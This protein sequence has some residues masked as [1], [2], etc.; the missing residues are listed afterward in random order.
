LTRRTDVLRSKVD[1]LISEQL[2]VDSPETWRNARGDRTKLLGEGRRTYAF[3]L[4]NSCEDPYFGGTIE[5]ADQEEGELPSEDR[6]CPSCAPQIQN[7]CRHP[8]EHRGYHVWKCRYCCRPSNHVCYGTVHFCQSCHDRNSVRV[9]QQHQQ[10]R[11]ASTGPPPLDAIPCLGGDKCGYPKPQG[12]E[13]HLNGPS[14][15][16]EQVYHCGLCI[17]TPSNTNTQQLESGSRNFIVNPSGQRGLT[18]WRQLNRGA[19]WAAEPSEIPANDTT[20]TNFVSSFQW[21]VMA[22]AV[23][24]HRLV[25]DPSAA[26]IEVAC[27]FMGRSDCPSIFRLEAIV[28]NDQQHV[29]CRVQTVP[30]DA[31]ADF[32]ERTS[33]LLEPTPGAHEIVMVVYGK[34]RR[35]WQGPFGSKVADC[36]VRVL[37]SDEDMDALLLPGE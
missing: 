2:Q 16:C 23:K 10:Q 13:K 9:R 11:G 3:Y 36:S 8:S 14:P 28:L 34:D 24:L 7:E 29:L 5:C 17:S 33:L 1:S 35:F 32:W 25:R 30:L 22:Q 26:R 19:S 15:S 6:L 27:R 12:K 18:G 20:R 37:C 21:C 31:P 4:C